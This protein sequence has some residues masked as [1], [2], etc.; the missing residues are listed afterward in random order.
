MPDAS[1]LEDADVRSH[2]LTCHPFSLNRGGE[3]ETPVK[4]SI[5]SDALI[6]SLMLVGV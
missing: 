4:R 6:C 3:T 5:T 2:K 1:Y